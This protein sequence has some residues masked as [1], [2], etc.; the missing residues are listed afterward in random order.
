MASLLVI[1]PARLNSGRLP[2]KMLADIGGVPLI[3]R[4]WQAAVKA[5]VGPVAVACADEQLVEAIEQAG[6]TGVLTDPN[7][8]SGSDRVWAAAQKL[9]PDGK[10]KWIINL[11]GDTPFFPANYLRR[12]VASLT[13]AKTEIVTL[14]APIT[15]EQ[16][17]DT[18]VVKA[19]VV[20][21]DSVATDSVA[22]DSVAMDS[23][24]QVVPYF[25]RAPVP[26]STRGGEGNAYH[27]HI[28]V[29]AWRREALAQFVALTPSALEKREG[30]EQLRALEAGMQISAI[31]VESFPLAV[32]TAEELELVRQSLKP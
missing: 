12:L 7:L 13:H 2:N 30:L 19:A 4:T 10:H 5:E 16:S 6:G 24:P 20:F 11:Q 17:T 27:G 28:G 18:A 22:T 15:Q 3:V 32:D 23:V 31:A 25:S 26:A 8:P 1:I 29:Y 9:D 21:A 14:C